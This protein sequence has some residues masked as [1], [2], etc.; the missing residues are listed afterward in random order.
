LDADDRDPIDLVSLPCRNP[1]FPIG[2]A[3][4]GALFPGKLVDDSGSRR[5]AGADHRQQRAAVSAGRREH[6]YSFDDA[7][8]ADRHELQYFEMF[9]NRGIYYKGW[10]AVTRHSVPWVMAP[11]P[12]FQGE[13]W[14]L[15]GPDDWTQARNLAKDN[16][17]KL[18][19]LQRLFLIEAVKYNVI[20]P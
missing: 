5:A 1:R 10:T 13:T 2:A 15:Y 9:C 4:I 14:E 8:A 20:P 6:V 11:L 19:E 16:P 18:Q 12:P 3:V 7:K 17:K